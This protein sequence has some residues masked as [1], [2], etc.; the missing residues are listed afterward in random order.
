VEPVPGEPLRYMVPSATRRNLVHLV[1]LASYDG[2]GECSCEH[3]EFRCRP[4][5]EAGFEPSSK[6]ECRHIKL[7]KEHF[8][9]MMIR[10]VAAAM[11]R[12]VSRRDG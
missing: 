12:R 9:R 8:C 7:A 11:K 5:L 4:R 1:D 10:K 6:L 3:F 2:N